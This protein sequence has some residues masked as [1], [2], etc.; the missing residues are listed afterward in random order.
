MACVTSEFD[1][2]S[3]PSYRPLLVNC[4]LFHSFSFRFLIQLEMH[5]STILLV[6]MFSF[7]FVDCYFNIQLYEMEY[8]S[9]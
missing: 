8:R 5:L 7:K 2:S 4:F 9:P 1:P 6:P 3:A